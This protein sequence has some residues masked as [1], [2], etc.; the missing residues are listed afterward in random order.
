MATR[1]SA[2]LLAAVVCCAAAPP[3]QLAVPTEPAAVVVAVKPLAPGPATTATA[4]A[5]SPKR[6]QL[7]VAV[8]PEL[9][10]AIN[11]SGE[12]FVAAQRVANPAALEATAAAHAARHDNASAII[13]ADGNA[14]YG[15]IVEA[16]DALQRGGIKNISFAAAKP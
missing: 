13:M 15:R 11:A 9:I 6:R 7:P 10:V 14:R 2:F 8:R 5:I 12:L 4:P 16:M 3:A 1:L